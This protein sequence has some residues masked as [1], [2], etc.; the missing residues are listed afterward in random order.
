MNVLEVLVEDDE[1]LA[2]YFD[3]PGMKESVLGLRPRHL[4]VAADPATDIGRLRCQLMLDKWYHFAHIECLSLGVV[5]P[6]RHWSPGE[7]EGLFRWIAT[8][9]PATMGLVLRWPAEGF[10]AT[11]ARRQVITALLPWVMAVECEGN[12]GY[13]EVC[14][15][16]DGAGFQGWVFKGV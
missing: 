10:V 16:L 1:D 11:P 4:A 2:C 8:V 6:L 7:V 3:D 5:M 9:P 15:F 14:H 12:E 13:Q